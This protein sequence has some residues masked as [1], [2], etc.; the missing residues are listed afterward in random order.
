MGTQQYFLFI[1][2]VLVAVNNTHIEIVAM[3]TQQYFLFIVNVLVAVNNTHIESVAMGTQQYFLFI[4][5]L[6]MSMPAICKTLEPAGKV[7]D[8]F[9]PF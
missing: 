9:V 2:N 6:R 3:G 4:I 1:V 7:P 8:I 5:A